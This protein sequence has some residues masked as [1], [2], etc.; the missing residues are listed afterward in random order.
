[1]PLR[2]CVGRTVWNGAVGASRYARLSRNDV[3]LGSK[4]QTS[5][6]GKTKGPVKG[7]FIFLAVE[8][9]LCGGCSATFSCVFPNPQEN[10]RNFSVHGP[11]LERKVGTFLIF[12]QVIAPYLQWA[13]SN[14]EI[15]G[16]PCG[17]QFTIRGIKA[18]DF[19]S[20]HIL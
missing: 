5:S 9:V 2:G 20:C 13:D 16:R 7:P 3:A 10:Y 4:Y 8:R 12:Q 6:D 14:Q 11:N 18:G 1:M 17:V 19:N 15:T